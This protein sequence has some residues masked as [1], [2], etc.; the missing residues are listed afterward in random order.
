M[1]FQISAIL[2]GLLAGQTIACTPG[3]KSCARPGGS[4]PR[5]YI[6]TCNSDKSTYTYT[7]CPN[8]QNCV[9]GSQGVACV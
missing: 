6:A 9:H 4:G 1:K 3:E 2:L 5:Q 8:N 7:K